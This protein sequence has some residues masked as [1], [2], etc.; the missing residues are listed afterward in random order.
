MVHDLSTADYR[1]AVLRDLYDAA[2][3]AH[4]CRHINFFARSVV[5]RDVDDPLKL[6][7]ATTQLP[8]LWVAPSMSWSKPRTR[9]M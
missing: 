9:R 1:E 3:I 4:E 7:R 5:A 6:D 2:R 8:H